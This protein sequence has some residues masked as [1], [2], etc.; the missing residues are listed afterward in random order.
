MTGALLALK[1]EMTGQA[2]IDL[3]LRYIR[4]SV[5]DAIIGLDARPDV[6]TDLAK[7]KLEQVAVE[8][9]KNMTGMAVDKFAE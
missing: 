1:R 3:I 4:Q 9:V 8:K 2:A 7:V 6:L 5:P